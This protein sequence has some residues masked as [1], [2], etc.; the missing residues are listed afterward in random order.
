MKLFSALD[1]KKKDMIWIAA[2]DVRKAL[3][4][5]EEIMAEERTDLT[6]DVIEHVGDIYISYA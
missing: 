4:K 6:I 1:K 2:K 5:A 3:D